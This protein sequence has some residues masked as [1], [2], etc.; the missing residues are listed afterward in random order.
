[1]DFF[2]KIFSTRAKEKAIPLPER[3]P[4]NSAGDFYVANQVCIACGAPE[5]EA[6]FGASVSLV[7]EYLCCK[8]GQQKISTTIEL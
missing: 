4:G 5:A 3:Y 2:K 6:P 1:M 7:P 8:P